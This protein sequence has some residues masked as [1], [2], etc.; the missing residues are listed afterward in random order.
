MFAALIAWG[1]SSGQASRIV[2][3][4]PRTGKRWRR[5]RKVISSSGRVLE[6][7]PVI[8]ARSRPEPSGRFLSQDERIRIADLRRDGL[9]AGQVAARLSRAPSTVRRELRRHAPE[10]GSYRPFEA[11]RQALKVLARPRCSRLAGDEQ[12]REYVTCRLKAH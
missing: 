8:S 7:A 6:Y 1:V 2:G 11:H 4:N 3:I 5:G 9:S 12:L 10:D